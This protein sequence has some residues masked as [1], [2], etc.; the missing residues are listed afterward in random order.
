MLARRLQLGDLDGRMRHAMAHFPLKEMADRILEKFYVAGGK[1]K[2][3]P[4]KSK[5]MPSATPG[6]AALE[7]MVVANFVEVFLAKEGHKGLVGVNLLVKIQVPTVPSLFG[8]MLAGVDF[9]LMGAGIPRAI[10][11]IL[12]KLSRLEPA[13]LPIDVSGA[14]PGDNFAAEFDPTPFVPPGVTELKRPNFLAIVTS[15][16]LATMLARKASGKVNGFVVEGATA[17]GHN[18]PPRGA[19]ELNEI[20]EPIYGPR[21]VPDLQAF[22]DL[23]LPFWLAGSYGSREGLK[24]ALGEG[25][26][27]IQVGTAF[28]F[29]QDSGIDPAVK[30]KVID[31]VLA[32]QAHVRTDPLASPTGYPFK[33]VELPDTVSDPVE[34]AQRTRICDL[35]YLREPYRL[36]NGT[37]G[38]RCASEPV[39]DYVK[40]GGDPADCVGRK[41][42]CNGLASTVGIAQMRKD[43]YLEQAIVTAGDQVTGI[44]KFLKPG[45]REY[46]AMDVL[47]QLLGVESFSEPEVEQNTPQH[48]H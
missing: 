46:T 44:G 7:L 10:P 12:D 8:A 28:A 22:R 24:E 25:A 15:A 32:G 6:M 35:G 20:G 4:F 27:G 19:L 17:G 3:T 37:L 41:C 29:C 16:S 45:Q 13:S 14:Q 1:L 47:D 18:A 34:Y 21:D 36:D 38:Y 40:K 5:P 23:G 33:V 9:V 2:A 43:G 30:A 11:G 31:T 26:A 42:I 39:E 48:A